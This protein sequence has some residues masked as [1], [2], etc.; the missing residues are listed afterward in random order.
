[1]KSNI[2]KIILKNVE[3]SL[4]E[5]DIDGM[6]TEATSKKEVQRIIVEQTRERIG[7]IFQ[8]KTLQNF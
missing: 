8:E 1:M 4:A 7:R 5:I 3:A 6:V 2:E